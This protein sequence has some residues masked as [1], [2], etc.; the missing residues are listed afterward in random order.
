MTDNREIGSRNIGDF[1]SGMELTDLEELT[2]CDFIK[3][4]KTFFLKKKVIQLIDEFAGQNHENMYYLTLSA[5]AYRDT[6]FFED[7]LEEYKLAYEEYQEILSG[8]NKNNDNVTNITTSFR[9][10]PD[11]LYTLIQEARLLKNLYKSTMDIDQKA[12]IIYKFPEEKLFIKILQLRK[13][14]IKSSYDTL[15]KKFF[16]GDEKQYQAL[17]RKFF[18]WKKNYNEPNV[19]KR[20]PTKA[21]IE[22]IYFASVGKHESQFPIASYPVVNLGHEPL[23]NELIWHT[24]SIARKLATT[25]E[26]ELKYLFKR[27]KKCEDYVKQKQ[28]IKDLVEKNYL[29]AIN[30][31]IEHFS[32]LDSKLAKILLA[33]LGDEEKQDALKWKSRGINN[34]NFALAWYNKKLKLAH[35]FLRSVNFVDANEIVEYFSFHYTEELLEKV[36]PLRKICNVGKPEIVDVLT[37]KPLVKIIIEATPNNFDTM[38][39]HGNILPNPITIKFLYHKEFSVSLKDLNPEVPSFLKRPPTAQ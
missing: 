18:R 3:N 34:M 26:E 8:K 6:T 28:K 38:M 16:S 30:Y 2:F 10:S 35:P 25:P 39:R 9:P 14:Q 29:P 4:T 23:V 19:G 22:F 13:K 36:E 15:L 24:N 11:Q 31:S 33:M 21:F 5:F 17:R 32:Y 1:L 12:E 37:Y 7:C 20:W 27:A